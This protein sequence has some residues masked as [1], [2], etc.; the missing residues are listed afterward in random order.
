MMAA[1]ARF[2]AGERVDAVHV[3]GGHEKMGAPQ[4]GSARNELGKKFWV[5]VPRCGSY[6]ACWCSF[7]LLLQWSACSPTRD[8]GHVVELVFLRVRTRPS[9]SRSWTRPADSCSE[10]ASC[11]PIPKNLVSWWVNASVRGRD[12][13]PLAPGP[14]R[15]FEHTGP[16]RCSDRTQ[17]RFARAREREPDRPLGCGPSRGG[18]YPPMSAPTL[19]RLTRQAR[20]CEE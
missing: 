2:W 7:R 10:A 16:R 18:R 6:L 1:V 4:A 8:P 14:A 15:R 11:T 9:T 5:G 12:H 13:G 3:R 17:E 20:P 19:G